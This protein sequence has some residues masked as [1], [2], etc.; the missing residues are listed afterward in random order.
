MPKQ[1]A[2]RKY[3][4]HAVEEMLLSRAE[5]A[6]RPDPLVG[7]VIAD[8]RGTFLGAAHRGGSRVGV[9]AEY[10]LIDE[11]LHDKDLEGA[12]LYVT[13]EPCTSCGQG[14][15]PC[16]DRV[17]AARIGRVFIGMP[18]P[19]P[20]IE[21][22]GISK[23]FNAGV[24]VEF[25]DKDLVNIVREHNQSFIDHYADTDE[26][27]EE[28]SASSEF[29]VESDIERRIVDSVAAADLSRPHIEEYL[30]LRGKS[31]D[32]PSNE[33]WE[34]LKRNALVTFDES[35]DSYQA[36][37]AGV[38]L[39]APDP[40]EH[41]IQMPVLVQAN[42]GTR[43][44]YEELSLP[45]ADMPQAIVSFLASYMRRF[46]VISGLQRVSMPEYPLEA[47]R[48]GI[49]NALVHRSF[50]EGAR[51]Q[52]RLLDDHVEIRSPG[53]P[54]LPLTV[55]RL[56]R[57]DAPP[58]SR[59]P[60]IADSMRRMGYM[61]ERGSGIGRMR[62]V[63][64]NSGLG[65]PE[66]SVDSGYLVLTLP[67]YVGDWKEVRFAGAAYSELD[68]S[69]KSVLMH[70]QEHGRIT[71]SEAAEILGIAPR[72]ARK[73]LVALLEAGFLAR[74]GAGSGTYYTLNREG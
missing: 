6:N 42:A 23:L 18:D 33:L 34:F 54:V 59:N 25:F 71:T 17:I 47:L 53:L 9:H 10:F 51:T 74:R 29:S 45:L 70:V 52:I 26:D 13:L 67:G 24:Q 3:M 63:L 56:Q 60:H 65:E 41:L 36:T 4:E 73:A 50:V 49:L 61:D 8:R 40:S 28:L 19:N 11:I 21:G 2:D 22:R 30:A 32:Y 66:Y 55:E 39:F 1:D 69:G 7:A 12:S 58:F 44:S 46:T 35:R 14:K 15:M 48:E 37:V 38:L 62:S 5:H 16:V 27:D 57:Y 31:F 43:E 68:S 72:N 64:L 20:N